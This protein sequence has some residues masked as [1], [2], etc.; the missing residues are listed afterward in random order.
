MAVYRSHQGILPVG[1]LAILPCQYYPHDPIAPLVPKTPWEA[2]IEFK[3]DFYLQLTLDKVH[4]SLL[5]SL[6]PL[7]RGGLGGAVWNADQ[8]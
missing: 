3:S 1:Y 4:S 8:P 7:F 5:K 6:N 2:T